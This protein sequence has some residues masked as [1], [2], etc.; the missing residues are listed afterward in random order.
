M[1]EE[2]P[3][4]KDAR[5]EREVADQLRK[6]RSPIMNMMPWVVM[7]IMVILAAA[8]AWSM[9]HQGG[10]GAAKAAGA[11]IKNSVTAAMGVK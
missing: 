1:A 8:I 7:F 6:L 9:V 3:V 10:A 2:N 5:I 11:G 4:I